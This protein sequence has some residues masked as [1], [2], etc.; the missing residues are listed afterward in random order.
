MFEKLCHKIVAW[1]R[2]WLREGDHSVIKDELRGIEQGPEEVFGGDAARC[3]FGGV[4][5]GGDS[6]FLF[7]WLA[8]EA[9]EVEIGDD[10]L[11]RALGFGELLDARAGAG[12]LEL[13]VE[14]ASVHEVERLRD[15][16]ADVALAGAVAARVWAAK[17]VHGA[18]VDF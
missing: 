12:A 5:C 14:G 11:G 9:G 18:R 2:G 10:F 6:E 13:R 17:G 15:A 16:R 7:G 4:G 3:A 8:A 1:Q